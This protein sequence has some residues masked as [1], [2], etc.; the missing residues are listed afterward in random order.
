MR[1]VECLTEI[2][3]DEALQI[4]TAKE[5]AIRGFMDRWQVEKINT[6]I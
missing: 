6:G 2:Y 3:Y 4:P 1:D 5:P